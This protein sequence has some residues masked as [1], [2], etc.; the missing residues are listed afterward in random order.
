MTQSTRLQLVMVSGRSGSGKSSA[1]H[2]LED[3]GF[4][5]VD[6]LPSALIP[7]LVQEFQHEK[8]LPGIVSHIQKVDKLA[9]GI[10]A[11]SLRLHDTSFRKLQNE[12]NHFEHVDTQIIYLD[13]NNDT[14]LRR[15]SETRRKHPISSEKTSLLEAL[16]LESQILSPLI[17]DTTIVIDS[18][19]MSLHQLRDEIAKM[20]KGAQTKMSLL[21][22]SFGFKH[23][24]PSDSD[25]IFD[26]R[27]LINP[28]WVPHLRSLTGIDE[29][30]AQ[31]L[32]EDD[33]VQEML[34]TITN[35]LNN[36]LPEYEINNRRYLT[37]SIGCTGGQHRSVF[38]T[39][40]LQKRFETH[41]QTQI[42]HRQLNLP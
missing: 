16:E 27:C 36:W 13:A 3:L 2:A 20:V 6:N 11:R 33:K 31:F 21:F 24:I 7:A 1:L 18:S 14:L 30:V 12:L 37:V 4:Y 26:V 35:Y 29:E 5:C 19:K 25:L 39:Q 22:Q 17:T 8:D 15:F 40:Q 9:I 23:G 10:D 38:L 28:H 41:W 34:D 42:R 32:Q